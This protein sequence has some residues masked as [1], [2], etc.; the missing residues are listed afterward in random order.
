MTN[1][2]ARDGDQGRHRPIIVETDE[3]IEEGSGD[4]RADK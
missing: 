2:S 4:S 1:Q 3:T